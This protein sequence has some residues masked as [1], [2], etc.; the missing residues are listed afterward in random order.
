MEF[1]HSPSFSWHAA[2]SKCN[3]F[4]KHVKQKNK[5]QNK[6]NKH[7]NRQ[8]SNLNIEAKVI[9]NEKIKNQPIAAP[10]HHEWKEQKGTH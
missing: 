7:S 1:L 2:T 5:K 3:R 8:S 10:F 4:F 6:T 9:E